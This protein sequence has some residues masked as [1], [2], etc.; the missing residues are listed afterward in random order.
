MTLL[1]RLKHPNIVRTIESFEED[2]SLHI[3]MEYCECGDL[4]MRIKSQAKSS[5]RFTRRQV[6]EWFVQIV[7][8]VGHIHSKDPAPRS[9]DKQCI[10]GTKQCCQAW[11]FWHRKGV[12]DG[13]DGG[14]C[15]RDSL[16]YVTGNMFEH[17]YSYESDMVRSRFFPSPS[18]SSS[19][20]HAIY[21]LTSCSM[22]FFFLHTLNIYQWSVGCILH[23]SARSSIHSPPT[24]F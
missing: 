8:A 6:L 18:A 10:S 1:T 15:D 13:L 11:R 22:Q 7:S 3:V 20:A 14:H 9:Q 16:L 17:P 2:D 12:A 23:E 5:K 24:I 4:A 19:F 21:R